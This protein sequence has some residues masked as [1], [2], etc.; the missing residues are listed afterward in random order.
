MLRGLCAVGH[1]PERLELM[2]FSLVPG[3]RKIGDEILSLP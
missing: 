2:A 1:I 3:W